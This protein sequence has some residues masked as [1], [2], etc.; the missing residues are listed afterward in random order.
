MEK[1]PLPVKTIKEVS[2]N[3][4]TIQGLVDEM[5]AYEEKYILPQKM[6]LIRNRLI[7]TIEIN[8]EL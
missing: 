7:R 8:K 3:I 1:K 4:Q 5:N 2:K 6:L